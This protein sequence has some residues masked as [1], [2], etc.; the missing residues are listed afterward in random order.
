MP[1]SWR[2]WAFGQDGKH[3]GLADG[4]AALVLVLH[5]I[6]TYIDGCSASEARQEMCIRDRAPTV[7]RDIM[8]ELVATLPPDRAAT[9]ASAL[10]NRLSARVCDMEIDERSDTA[11]VSD[12]APVFAALSQRPQEPQ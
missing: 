3:A 2:R 1:R 9:F 4:S 11:M 6:N 7:L 12:L 8:V 5:C 10:G